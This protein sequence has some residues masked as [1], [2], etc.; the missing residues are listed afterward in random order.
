[1]GMTEERMEMERRGR[2][3]Q[4]HHYHQNHAMIFS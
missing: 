4:Q 3:G 1:M 2:R